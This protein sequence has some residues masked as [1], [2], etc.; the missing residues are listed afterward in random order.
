MLD[1]NAIMLFASVVEAGSYTRAAEKL[2]IPKSTISRRISQMEKELDV[3]LLQRNTRGLSLTQ[4]GKKVY[5]GSFNILREARAVQATVESTREGISGQLRITAP[6]SINQRVLSSLCGSYLQQYPQVELDVQFTNGEVDLI[7]DGFDIAIVFGP[8][9]NS[10]LIAKPLFKRDMFLVAS[11]QYLQDHDTPTDIASLSDHAGI[12]LGNQR[13][14]PIWPMGI[15]NK[16]LVSFNAKVRANSVEMLK[17]MVKDG[18]GVAMM[19]STDCQHELD[20]GEFIQLLS[21]IPIEPLQAFGLYSSRHQ[22]A[23]KITSFLEYFTQHID[24]HESHQVLKLATLH[25]V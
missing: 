21:H 2:G 19:T 23:S 15:E 11:R 5:E 24:S 8:L 14:I 25:S 4:V 22:L 1:L 18:I 10:D 9:A 16:T 13:S 17:Q 6:I 20:S 3:R 12:L 7:T